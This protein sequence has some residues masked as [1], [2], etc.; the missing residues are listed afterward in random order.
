MHL[1][2]NGGGFLAFLKTYVVLLMAYFR[3]FLFYLLA[4]SGVIPPPP[5]EIST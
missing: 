4:I 3:I 2:L 5:P 1:I